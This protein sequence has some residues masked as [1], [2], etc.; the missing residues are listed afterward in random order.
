MKPALFVIDMQ[1][2]FA[3]INEKTK[4]SLYEAIEY[5]NGAIERFRDKNLPIVCIQHFDEED[6]LTPGMSGFE[7]FDE[8]KIKPAD[9]HIYKTYGNAFNQTVLSEKLK[10]LNVDTVI[11]TGFCAEY[12]VLSTCRG[13]EDH[14]LT[15]VIFRGALASVKPENI[16]NIEEINDVISYRALCKMIEN[17]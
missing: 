10:E 7:I 5:I 17:L 14:D 6:N 3:E 15:P 13:A 2:Q 8:I 4:E 11:L 12:C 16:K 9:L 1:K